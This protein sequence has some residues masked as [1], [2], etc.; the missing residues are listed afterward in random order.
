MNKFPMA[1]TALLLTACQTEQAAEH[2]QPVA[3]SS[4]AD[5]ALDNLLRNPEFATAG[6][7]PAPSGWNISQHA[8]VEAYTIEL[9]EGELSIDKYGEQHWFLISQNVPGDA[10]AGHPARFSAELKLDLHADGWTQALEPGGGLNITIRGTEPDAPFQQKLLYN[11]SLQHQPRLGTTDWTPV[12]VVFDVPAGAT[13][14][15]VG[16]LHQ[17]YGQMMVRNPMLS[18]ISEQASDC[19]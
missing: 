2:S 15:N 8:G 11:S 19:N 14:L 5:C 17:A 12:E 6:Q 10:L 13:R 18:M 4:S 1:L 7:G 3:N 9:V 16:F